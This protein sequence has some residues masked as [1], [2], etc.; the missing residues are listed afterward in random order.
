MPGQFRTLAIFFLLLK[1]GTLFTPG[2]AAGWQWQRPCAQRHPGGS[3][4]GDSPL[5]S[6][7]TVHPPVFSFKYTTLYIFSFNY[8]SSCVLYLASTRYIQQKSIQ[9]FIAFF[10]LHVYNNS[11]LRF[12][13]TFIQL[14]IYIPPSILCFNCPIFLYSAW[15]I[16][17]PLNSAL[18]IQLCPE[19]SFSCFALNFNNLSF[20][21]KW[22]WPKKS[23]LSIDFEC[24]VPHKLIFKKSH[25]I[26][27][28]C[29]AWITK[30]VILSDW[31]DSGAGPSEN[32]KNPCIAWS[33]YTST[34]QRAPVGPNKLWIE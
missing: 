29:V 14:L 24:L 23:I 34:L 33:I 11:E 22:H 15:N 6:A 10:Q 26:A 18:N 19:F 13:C 30:E 9:I 32:L 5:Y 21:L 17:I 3:R 7:W 1:S 31:H 12:N 8:I 20:A 25:G 2:A 28:T 27:W 4:Q 16:N